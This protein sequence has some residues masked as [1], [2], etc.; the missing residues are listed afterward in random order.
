MVAVV[1]DQVEEFVL[2]VIIQVIPE[3]REVE[4]MVLILIQALL[5][6]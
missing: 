6:E 2:L 5:L 1:A 3:V 4:L